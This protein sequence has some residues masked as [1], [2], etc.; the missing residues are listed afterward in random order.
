MNHKGCED[1]IEQLEV[2]MK[3]IKEEETDA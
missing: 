1:L 3:Q 2:F